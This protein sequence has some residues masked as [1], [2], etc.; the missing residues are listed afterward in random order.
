MMQDWRGN[1]LLAVISEE[2]KPT[3]QSHRAHLDCFAAL[4]MTSPG[5]RVSKLRFWVF[6]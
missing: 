6:R 4:A 3:K 5:L 2:A 1:P